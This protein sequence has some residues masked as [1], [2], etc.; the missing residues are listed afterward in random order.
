MPQQLLL[1]WRRPLQLGVA[2]VGVRTVPRRRGSGF[3]LA[4]DVD[5]V[6]PETMDVPTG[7]NT[8]LRQLG[9]GFHHVRVATDRMLA[10]AQ[11]GVRM[12][13]RSRSHL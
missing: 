7:V 8:V 1:I 11:V 10:L 4:Q 6:W 13:Q 9:N 12:S 3:L 2:R 5:M